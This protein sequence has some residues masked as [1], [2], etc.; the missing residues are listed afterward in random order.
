MGVSR[1]TT[2]PYVLVRH[3]EANGVH[4]GALTSGAWQKCALNSLVIDTHGLASLS[5]NKITLA[6]GV[7]RFKG[8]APAVLTN[9]HQLRLQNITDAAT[10]GVGASGYSAS[11][12]TQSID[13]FVAGRFTVVAGRELEFQRRCETT[14]ASYGMGNAANFSV[15]EVYEEIEFWR[16]G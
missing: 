3:E 13:S 14:S 8:R 5:A 7:Y 4:G 12:S 16:E 15:G 1:R 2:E 10:L 11:G 9:R 6:P